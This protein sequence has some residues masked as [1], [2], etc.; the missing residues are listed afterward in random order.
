M[1]G[2]GPGSG[3][4]KSVD[5]GDTWT[6][7]AGGIPA[8]PLGRIGLDTYRKNGNIVYASIEAP[9]PGARRGSRQPTRRRR[10]AAP[11]R[12]RGGRGG[13]R[14][15]AAADCRARPACI[16]PTTAARRGAR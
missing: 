7:L 10:R 3:I 5:G 16:A 6:R 15:G 11:A 12:R 13:G 14:G 4:W 8:G 1:N 2:G 9:T